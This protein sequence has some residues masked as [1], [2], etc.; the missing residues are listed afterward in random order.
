MTRAAYVIAAWL[1]KRADLLQTIK[2]TMQEAQ[3]GELGSG[4]QTPSSPPPPIPAPSTP[5][6]QIQVPNVGQGQNWMNPK[7]PVGGANA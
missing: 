3:K 5:P 2:K 6:A 7:K 4:A 1:I